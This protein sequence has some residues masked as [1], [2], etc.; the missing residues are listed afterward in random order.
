MDFSDVTSRTPRVLD[1][2]LDLFSRVPDPA[3]TLSSP[4]IAGPRSTPAK[5]AS[6]PDIQFFSAVKA[7]NHFSYHN[8]KRSTASDNSQGTASS[9]KASG[10]DP[11]SR[12]LLLDR[13]RSFTALNWL[14]PYFGE[15]ENKLTELFC[16]SYGWKC[17]AISRSCSVK[18]SL[19]CTGC[20]R[21]LVLTFN[22]LDTQPSF[23]ACEFEIED[24]Q[25]LNV[26]LKDQYLN[27]I[28]SAAHSSSC[29]WRTFPC[30]VNATYYL[31]PHINSTNDTLIS[32]YLALLHRLYTNLA[33][34]D[35][36]SHTLAGLAPQQVMSDSTEFIRVSNSWL[37]SR[38]FKD[39]K[40]N[41]APM[42]QKT[43]PPWAYYLAAM[44]WD[45]QIQAH[46][47]T[48]NSHGLFHGR[49]E[50]THN[51][52]NGISFGDIL[53]DAMECEPEESA[54]ACHKHWCFLASSFG[55]TSYFSY[56]HDMIINSEANIGPEGHYQNTNDD[57]TE[58]DFSK[59]KL[60]R[61]LSIDVTE[62]L[63]HFSKLRKLYFAETN[64]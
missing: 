28:K 11:F 24:I 17:E 45:L 19:R 9:K 37:L 16:S 2:C 25:D 38:Y 51:L 4:K 61:K 50:S 58:I 43:L 48:S 27:Q 18:N 1:H 41:F 59:N 21:H 63:E 20:G 39:S 12:T 60:K 36:Y 35:H 32:G 64:S 40:E 56:F 34:A 6:H 3:D 10:F 33:L 5:Y 22:S 29:P 53:D 47:N 57:F 52:G 49:S 55:E 14:L 31:T 54:F 46:G 13:L 62:N 15:E 42:L 44:G 7:K 26:K 30:P 23:A 8:S